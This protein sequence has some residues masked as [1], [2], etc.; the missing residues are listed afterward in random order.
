MQSLEKAFGDEVARPMWR[1]PKVAQL[2]E[3]YERVLLP[4]QVSDR[5]TIQ[6]LLPSFWARSMTRQVNERAENTL[7]NRR[8]G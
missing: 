8:H 7:K 1:Q 6:P 4:G 2:I 5:S 3:G